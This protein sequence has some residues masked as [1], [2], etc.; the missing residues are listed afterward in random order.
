MMHSSSSLISQ[1]HKHVGDRQVGVDTSSVCPRVWPQRS[2]GTLPP[3]SIVVPPYTIMVLFSAPDLVSCKKMGRHACMNGYCSN[4]GV[5]PLV[6]LYLVGIH[7]SVIILTRHNSCRY[8]ERSGLP[9]AGHRSTCS[10]VARHLRLNTS[11]Y[12]HRISLAAI[13][14]SLIS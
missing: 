1:L 9:A 7:A 10:T 14:N 12:T 11:P 3:N 5:I 4:P 2:A 6:R 13:I 8:R